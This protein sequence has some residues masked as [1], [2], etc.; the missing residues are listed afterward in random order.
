MFGTLETENERLKRVF[1]HA[2]AER[3]RAGV[4]S[5]EYPCDEW[6]CDVSGGA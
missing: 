5:S 2:R 3:G 1:I 4:V 6:S